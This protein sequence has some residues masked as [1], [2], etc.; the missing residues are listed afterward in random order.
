MKSPWRW[1]VLDMVAACA[2][3]LGWRGKMLT[4]FVHRFAVV[5]SIALS[6]LLAAALL[7]G[8][9]LF[10]AEPH[11][12]ALLEWV[13]AHALWGPSAF[14]AVYMLVVILLLPGILFTLGAGFLFGIVKGS[15]LV[16]VAE[17]L[18]ATVAFLAGRL[19]SRRYF[20][21]RLA[22]F[23]E[24]H[25]RF[26]ILDERVGRDEW[27]VVLL[28]RMIPFFPFKLSNYIFGISRFSLSSFVLGTLFGIVPITVT[29][30]YIGSLAADLAT[31]G[32]RSAARSNLEWA[33]YGIGLVVAVVV[34]VFIA[35]LARRALYARET[36]TERDSGLGHPGDDTSRCL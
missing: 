26:A 8:V 23:L 30:V 27:K 5:A 3:V 15:L 9:A 14:M 24:R 22:G 1:D 33:M 17:T 29:N 32:S 6:I 11:V 34:A 13:D 25:P 7:T 12:L 21:A 16:I 10:E 28:T 36:R 18:G 4:R 19:I 20:G 35:R 2:D 31:L